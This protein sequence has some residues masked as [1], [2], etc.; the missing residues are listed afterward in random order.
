M[1][2]KARDGCGTHGHIGT[3]LRSAACIFVRGRRK[4][5]TKRELFLAEMTQFWTSPGFVDACEG[6]N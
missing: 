5:R 6:Q 4:K 2:C 3:H 1:L